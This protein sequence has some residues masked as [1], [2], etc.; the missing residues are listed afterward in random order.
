MLATHE[1]TRPRQASLRCAISTAYYALFHLLTEDAT[2]L[3]VVGSEQELHYTIRR[4]FE[5]AHMKAV[6][7]AFG[8]GAPGLVWADAL[9]GTK[10]STELETVAQSFVELQ[11]SRHQA[12]YDV[13]KSSTR[14]RTLALVDQASAA[15]VAWQTV[16]KQRDALV[17]LTALTFKGRHEA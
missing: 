7:K 5:H 13:G 8:S 9:R 16:R 11:G 14:T 10:V 6:A 3:F 4:S 15:F 17:F 2:R 1:R 12:D